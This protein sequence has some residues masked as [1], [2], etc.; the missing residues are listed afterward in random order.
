MEDEMQ[1]NPFSL[2]TFHIYGPHNKIKF[3]DI[4]LTSSY[5]HWGWQVTQTTILW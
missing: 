3:Y 5:W 1:E 4:I 2:L